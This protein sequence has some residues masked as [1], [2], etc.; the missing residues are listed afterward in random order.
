MQVAMLGTGWVGRVLSARMVEVGHR[1]TMGTRDP[2][3]TRARDEDGWFAAHDAV[4]LLAMRDAVDGADVVVNATAGLASEEAFGLVGADALDGLVVLDAA[5]ALDFS[6]GFPP[7]LAMPP[8]ESLAE[9][10]QRLAPGA[11]VV[12]AFNTMSVEVMVDPTIVPGGHDLPIAGDDPDA[13]AVVVELVTSM[14]WRPDQVRDLGALS[15]AR[16][17]EAFLPLWLSVMQQLGH[18]AF[19]VRFVEGDPSRLPA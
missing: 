15:A 4:G 7:R 9:R 10:L 3:A 14:G 2:D 6:G 1:V 5:N 18:R 17:M 12:K 11:R 19:N 8:G 13:K 16:G